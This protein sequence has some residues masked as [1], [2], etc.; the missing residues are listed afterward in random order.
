VRKL[1]DPIATTSAK[2]IDDLSGKIFFPSLIASLLVEVGP[3]LKSHYELGLAGVYFSCV[4]GGLIVGSITFYL[5]GKAQIFFRTE[6]NL[7]PLLGIVLMPMGFVCL[8]PNYFASFQPPLGQ[9]SGVAILAWAF[10]LL[11]PGSSKSDH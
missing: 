6:Q 5:L 4:F 2:A 1:S 10:M 11:D 3:W 8:F 7:A 9:V